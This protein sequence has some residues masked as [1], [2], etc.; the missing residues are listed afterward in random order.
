[1]PEHRKLLLSLQSA[2]RCNTSIRNETEFAVNDFF[3]YSQ[4]PR[5][6]VEQSENNWSGNRC[7]GWRTIVRMLNV[8]IALISSTS[9][10]KPEKGKSDPPHTALAEANVSRRPYNL[11]CRV[12]EPISK[13]ITILNNFFAYTAIRLIFTHRGSS[14]WI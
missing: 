2:S 10:P 1:M 14:G 6:T 5:R 7:N 8:L 4:F 11:I 12:C 13:T 9:L 3:I